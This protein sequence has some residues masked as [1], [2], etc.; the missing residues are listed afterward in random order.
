MIIKCRA[1][2]IPI[3][4]S[5]PLFQRWEPKYLQGSFTSRKTFDWSD[6]EGAALLK[7]MKNIFF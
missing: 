2:L 3:V 4:T 1:L 6:S 5:L 7:E